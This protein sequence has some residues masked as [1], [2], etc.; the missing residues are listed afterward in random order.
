MKSCSSVQLRC[1]YYCL[2][3]R[4]A[5]ES[6]ALATSFEVCITVGAAAT[7]RRFQQN[8]QKF[9]KMISYIYKKVI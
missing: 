1:I 2:D 5:P 9:G 6:V 8:M 3:Y 4:Y 7:G